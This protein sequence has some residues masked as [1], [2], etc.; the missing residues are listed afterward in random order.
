M[1]LPL[2]SGIKKV[3]DAGS[4]YVYYVSVKGVTGSGGLNVAEVAEKLKVIRRYT[5]MPIGVGFGIRDDETARAVAAVAA[6]GLPARA[7][8]RASLG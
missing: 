6:T 5:E 1:L 8:P 2:A 4:G 3:C 7:Q